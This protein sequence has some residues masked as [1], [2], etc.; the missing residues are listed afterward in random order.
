MGVPLYLAVHHTALVKCLKWPLATL[1]SVMRLGTVSGIPLRCADLS[2]LSISTWQTMGSG[3]VELSTN[4]PWDTLFSCVML[5]N[6]FCDHS[7]IKTLL[8]WHCLHYFHFV[9]SLV[10]VQTTQNSSRD[11]AHWPFWSLPQCLTGRQISFHVNT[12]NHLFIKFVVTNIMFP[13]MRYFSH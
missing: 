1:E 9:I 4:E 12:H 3:L 11:V 8:W 10:R 6:H 5:Q 2:C 13:V 7:V